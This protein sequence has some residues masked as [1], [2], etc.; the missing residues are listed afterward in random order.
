MIWLGGQFVAAPFVL[1]RLK[2][3]VDI[4]RKHASRQ[5]QVLS[6]DD[7][8]RHLPVDSARRFVSLR[9]LCERIQQNYRGLSPASQE[10]LTDQSAKFD[11]ILVSC[12]R[13]LWL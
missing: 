11:A 10:V 12:L 13:R 3:R 6:Q 9:G 7:M 4:E 8:F 1:E 2:R 5:V